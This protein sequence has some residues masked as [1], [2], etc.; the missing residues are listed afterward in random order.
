MGNFDWHFTI[1]M[2]ASHVL[3]TLFNFNFL[4]LPYPS[5]YAT[6]P[7]CFLDKMRLKWRSKT[8]LL[9][10]FVT[11]SSSEAHNRNHLSRQTKSSSRMNRLLPGDETSIIP[12]SRRS[13]QSSS[14]PAAK[15]DESQTVEEIL[16]TAESN[17]NPVSKSIALDKSDIKYI[18]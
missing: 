11:I 13:R 5:W 4:K 16:D 17:V 2:L 18:F 8:F 1:Q 15:L 10:L 9:V 6:Y 3:H 14:T 7:I 12:D